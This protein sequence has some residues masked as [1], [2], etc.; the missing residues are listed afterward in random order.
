MHGPILANNPGLADS[1][2]DTARTRRGLAYTDPAPERLRE[3]DDRAREARG[4]IAAN[5][6]SE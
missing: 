1:L 3:I 6:L 4:T 5:P 2:L